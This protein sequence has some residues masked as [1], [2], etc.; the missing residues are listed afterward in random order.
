M[1]WI[2]LGRESSAFHETS[3]DGLMESID[4]RERKDGAVLISRYLISEV[5]RRLVI[6]M[7]IKTNVVVRWETH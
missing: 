1:A 7:M 6:E 3:E 5:L 4:I 2:S